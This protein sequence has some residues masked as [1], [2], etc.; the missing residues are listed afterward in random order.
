MIL[1]IISKFLGFGREMALSY[2]FGASATTDAFLISQ[3]IP[4]QIFSFISAGIATSFIP[5]YSRILKEEGKEGAHRYTNNLSNILL[6]L[7]TVVVVIVFLFTKPLVKLFAQGFTGDTLEL[8]LKFTRIGVF[9]VY[10]SALSTIFAGY[11]RLHDNYILPTAA[12]FPINLIIIASLFISA[13]TNVYVLAVGSVLAAASQVLLLAPLI[14]KTGYK[15]RPVID[16]KDKYMKMM[17]MMALPVI[18]G[19]SVS[20]INVLVD[21][22]LASAIAVGGISA[23]N[24]ADRINGFVNGFFVSSLVTV[25]Y[26]T[27]A[28]MAVEDNTKGLKASI[29]ESLSIINLV[30]IPATIGAMLFSKEIV[31]LL[32]GRGAFTPEA[33]QMTGTALFFYSLG[34]APAGLRTVLTRTFYAYQDT[35]TPMINST[36]GVTINIVLNVILSRFLGLG[37]LALATSISSVVTAFLM[38]VTL[39]KK[40]G[41]FGL[42]K[43]TGSF[44]K[45]CIASVIM[46]TA[47]YASFI[48]AGI[49]IKAN[50]SLMLAI[51]VGVLSYGAVIYFMR[52]PEVDSTINIVKRRMLNFKKKNSGK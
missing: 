5:M 31:S 43:I 26:P 12:A 34:M 13:R 40:I 21:R 7:A 44:I 28:K 3:T 45:I 4:S 46:G 30:V 16:F 9:G 23:L 35:K 33:I 6:M 50:L 19:S 2:N 22:T 25:L 41:P 39:R 49:Y 42:R 14:R 52:I 38:F 18:V 27:I 1:S 47:A 51:A 10:F 17:I 36:I 48:F 8:A 29:G 32:F 15:H 11:L 24:Y 20:R 37:G